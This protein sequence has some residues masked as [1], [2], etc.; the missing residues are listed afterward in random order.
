MGLYEEQLKQRRKADNEGLADALQDLAAAASQRHTSAGE[1]DEARMHS[2]LEQVLRYY[3]IKCRELPPT[4]KTLEDMLEHQCRPHGMMRRPVKLDKLWYQDAVGAM[5][6]FLRSGTPVALLPCKGK[7]YDYYD[8]ASGKKV[9]LNEQTAAALEED[10]IAFYRPFPQKKLGV[11]DL[12]AYI[13]QCVPVS[14][15]AA[16]LIMMGVTTLVGTLSPKITYLLYQQVIPSGSPRLLLAVGV[17]MICAGISSLL[18]GIIHSMVSNNI[19][20][21]MGISVQ[22]ATMARLFSL[23]ADFFRQYSAG[24]LS[25]RAQMV[26]SLCST[27]SSAFVVSGLSAVFSLVYIGQ[28]FVYAPSLV[29]P[30]VVMTCITIG[31]MLLST[32]L[33]M[34][35]SREAMRS[36]SQLSGMTYALISGIQKI[37]LAGA[38]K[39]VFARWTRLYTK[40]VKHTYDRPKYLLL[41]GTVSTAISL[42][43]TIVMYYFAVR[44]G[45]SM[46]EYNAFNASYGMVSGAFFTLAGMVNSVAM[47]R[48]VLEMAKPILDAVPETSEEKKMV[49]SLRGRVELSHLSFRYSDTMP[50]VLDDLSLQIKSGEYVAIVGKTGCGKSTLVRLLL[51][52]ET[53]QKG[54]IY[55]DG[56]DMQTLD[57]RSLRRNI[58]TV[59]QDGKLFQGSIYENIAISAPGLTMNEAWE[60]AELAGIADDIRAMPMGMHTLISE[61]QGGISGGQRQRRDCP[62]RQCLFGCQWRLHHTPG[63]GHSGLGEPVVY[64]RLRRRP[65]HAHGWRER[66]EVSHG[67][68]CLERLWLL[69]PC[70]L[71]A[72]WRLEPQPL[73]TVLSRPALSQRGCHGLH[74]RCQLRRHPGHQV[75]RQCGAQ[76]GCTALLRH[77]FP[78]LAHPACR[79]TCGQ[80]LRSAHVVQRGRA[81]LRA[82]RCP[83]TQ[84][85]EV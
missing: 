33:S 48:P 63:L 53:P 84:Q 31:Y 12:F 6:G 40:E 26:D 11:R 69:R 61:G 8:P 77:L 79:G 74:A 36:S 15:R 41:S 51:G 67:P 16:L 7:G 82:R 50:M 38:E 28:V 70:Q 78:P 2:A 21:Q 42:L 85:Q 39:R 18:F 64:G 34:N 24:E 57:L 13:F 45:V 44:S 23:P 55:Y 20:V 1:N 29:V 73:R 62:L 30:S 80:R 3:G 46:A 65:P 17:F 32:R 27:L 71:P 5:L 47:I 81:H 52:L 9:H 66:H 22:A 60:A 37:K 58:G 75:G 59:I 56:L 68:R 19:N 4:V 72:L 14:S 83:D 76:P 10:A 54:A 35:E 43:G 25:S 49:Q